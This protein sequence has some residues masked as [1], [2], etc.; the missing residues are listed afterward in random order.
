MYSSLKWGWPPMED[1]L[2]S[3]QNGRWP[4]NTKNIYIYQQ[5]LVSSYSELKSK[6][7]EPTL[8]THQ[9]QKKTTSYGGQIWI[10]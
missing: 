7:E 1:Y 3:P 8:I 10:E 9:C 5:L 6:L 2:K 4:Q